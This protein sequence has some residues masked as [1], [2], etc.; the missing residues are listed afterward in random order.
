MAVTGGAPAQEPTADEIKA[1][2]EG[3]QYNAVQAGLTDL[4]CRVTWT[5]GP[6]AS[7]AQE[8]PEVAAVELLFGAPDRFRARLLTESGDE[9]DMG[10][11]QRRLVELTTAW[12]LLGW[13]TLG[14]PEAPEEPAAWLRGTPLPGA[15]AREGQL[16]RGEG[17]LVYSY[18]I[19]H[20]G[21][22]GDA[23]RCA[24]VFDEQ[25]RLREHRVAYPGASEVILRYR[26]AGDDHVLPETHEMSLREPD[27]EY[28]RVETRLKYMEVE[29]YWLLGEQRTIGI[30]GDGQEEE[31]GT[32]VF[33]EHAVN[34]GIPPEELALPVPP[35]VTLDRDSPEQLIKSV[36]A[37]A[38]GGDLL[39]VAEC[40]AR[41]HQEEFL[42]QLREVA[43]DLE[44]R[45]QTAPLG[46]GDL[47]PG[48][49]A[50]ECEP[51][52]EIEFS[53]KDEKAG[54][55]HVKTEARS[56]PIDRDFKLLQ[57]GNWRIDEPVWEVFSAID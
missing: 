2:V 46:P 28:A 19:P 42:E 21:R 56:G 51:I 45:G 8:R 3:Q 50:W 37:A 41:R 5:G 15:E 34:T 57:E 17:A 13:Q 31:L 12:R 39:A 20:P 54:A 6:L 48:M 36:Y 32:V 25:W 10:P 47:Y 35:P 40:F 7:L 52:K 33:Q 18:L 44:G 49:F 53:G 11:A 24:L 23:T 27:A 16:T 43:P 29:G 1:K 38:A 9:V 55:I 26:Q 30:D 22:Q 4:R 14:W